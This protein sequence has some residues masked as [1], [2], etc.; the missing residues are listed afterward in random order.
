[1]LCDG[2]RP[3]PEECPGFDNA[4]HQLQGGAQLCVWSGPLK[5][6]LKVRGSGVPHTQSKA[7]RSAV[8]QLVEK[9]EGRGHTHGTACSG[10]GKADS[11]PVLLAVASEAGESKGLVVGCDPLISSWSW[12]SVHIVIFFLFCAAARTPELLGQHSGHLP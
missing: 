11:L 6:A 1:M 5:G 9:G 3:P 8:I 12:L 4:V 7:W 10:H 2:G